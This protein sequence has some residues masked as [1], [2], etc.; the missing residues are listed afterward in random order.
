M[1]GAR[2]EMDRLLPF[3]PDLL[4]GL[5]A[6]SAPDAHWGRERLQVFGGMVRPKDGTLQT[7]GGMTV[8]NLSA[9]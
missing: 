7:T 1:T 6:R 2:V 4:P 5:L 8:M 9:S 3:V